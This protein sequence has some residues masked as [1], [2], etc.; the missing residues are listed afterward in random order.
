MNFSL[1]TNQRKHLVMILPKN[2]EAFLLEFSNL[3]SLGR[4]NLEWKTGSTRKIYVII[5][6]ATKVDE[7][8]HIVGLNSVAYFFLHIVHK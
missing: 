3:L 4:C 6:D 5:K 8:V 7:I 2:K 1:Y